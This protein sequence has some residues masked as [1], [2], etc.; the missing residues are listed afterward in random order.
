MEVLKI[1]DTIVPFSLC[2]FSPYSF[3]LGKKASTAS[4]VVINNYAERRWETKMVDITVDGVATVDIFL[5]LYACFDRFE[6]VFLTCD[7]PNFTETTQ[8]ITRKW[9]MVDAAWFSTVKWIIERSLPSPKSLEKLSGVIDL[10]D[11]ARAAA[12][13]I[14]GIGH[15][16][17]GGV[18]GGGGADQ[19]E[20]EATEAVVTGWRESRGIDLSGDPWAAAERDEADRGIRSSEYGRAVRRN[21]GALAVVS[22]K[23]PEV[24]STVTLEK[25]LESFAGVIPAGPATVTAAGVDGMGFQ[26]VNLARGGVTIATG[27]SWPR[28]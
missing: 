2:L 5:N 24:G 9:E 11:R 18:W 3:V 23:L 15:I 20:V 21:F 10:Y 8:S 28:V 26:F 25:R 1:L 7:L 27:V 12:G 6:L 16:G 4:T 13:R 14:A 22:A 19:R 17:S